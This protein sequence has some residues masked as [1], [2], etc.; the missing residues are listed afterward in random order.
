MVYSQLVAKALGPVRSSRWVV[1]G[2]LAFAF[3]ALTGALAAAGPPVARASADVWSAV[4]PMAEP[5]AAATATLLK[6]GEVLVAG[7]YNGFTE[8]V[9]GGTIW[10]PLAELFDPGTRSW[11]PTAPMLVPR[12]EPQAALLGDGRVLVLGVEAT[13]SCCEGTVGAETF[14]PET[15][16]WSTAAAP[17]EMRDVET[18]TA[19]PG[20]SL[21]A[22]GHFGGPGG[23]WATWTLGAAL[24]DPLSG[25]WSRTQPPLV[26]RDFGATAT[27]LGTGQ[28]LL[29]GGFQD[30]PAKELPVHDNY[31]VFASAE[32][33]NPTSG[34]W[35][36]VAPMLHPRTQQAATAMA[37][38]SA[39]IAGGEEEIILP[40]PMT[41]SNV[42]S[43]AEAFDPYS[44]TWQPLRAMSFAR[45]YAEAAT[46]SDGSVI[47]AG[48]GECSL[49]PGY[50]ACINYGDSP[51]SSLCCAAS[52]A[53][54]YEPAAE[55][56]TV[57]GPVLAGDETA[58]A[59]F[60]NEALLA[61][62]D[63]PLNSR[64]LNSAYV[65]GPPPLPATSSQ[66]PSTPSQ[67]TL[68]VPTLTH[69]HQSHRR[70]RDTRTADRAHR[71]SRPTSGTTF[72]FVLNEPAT[73]E[74]VFVKHVHGY[75]ISHECVIETRGRH[76]RPCM[77]TISDGSLSAA[78]KVGENAVPFDGHTSRLHKLG[79]G[80]YTLEIKAT[81]PAGRSET[82]N[83]SFTIL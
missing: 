12:V 6:D 78:G 3:P 74:L 41:E 39:L 70:W 19:L 80:S 22:I 1:V 67:A 20:G 64:D 82:H 36:P 10:Q 71:E 21:L 26:K 45:V 63:L 9:G 60:G 55:H 79:P 69:L 29:V 30:E 24:Y 17:A 72:S 35:T 4:A 46:L 25:T 58:L 14:D 61:G 54:I 83:L 52:T 13:P 43:S 32:T 31:T 44:G 75:E 53:E 27:L 76:G 18:L 34:V 37:N 66:P 5:R 56:W 50:N 16:S 23:Y 49:A 57:T 38:G 42:Q 11:R 62:G 28:V 47:V 68:P 33:Y 48:G 81:N 77:R 8:H 40:G 51:Y 2:I 7:G 15:D 65:Y 59:A 73:V